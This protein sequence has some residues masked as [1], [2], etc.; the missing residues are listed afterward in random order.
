MKIVE[1][2]GRSVDLG[3]FLSRPI[4]GFLATASDQGPRVSPVWFLWEHGAIWIIGNRK[5]DTFPNRVVSEPRAAIAFVDF[6]PS[7]G[8]VHH[9]GMRGTAAVEEWNKGRAKRILR[10]Y[11]GP[12][13]EDWDRER[14]AEPLDDAIQAPQG[15]KSVGRNRILLRKRGD[16]RNVDPTEAPPH[17]L[18]AM[19]SA[20]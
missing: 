7:V 16:N 6:D 20:R 3:G 18:H 12:S 2:R 8:L 1:D 19:S 11:L 15:F 9:V 10:R 14:F 17:I 4:F 5:T 13:E